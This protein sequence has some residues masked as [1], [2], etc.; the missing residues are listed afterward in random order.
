MSDPAPAAGDDD[1]APGAVSRATAGG[2]LRAARQAQGLHIAA[3]AASI[4]VPQ[5]K[6]E[7]LEADR[8]D[9]L[10]DLT[11]ARALA[12]TVCRSLKIDAAPVMALLPQ[13]GERSLDK[14][15]QGLNTAFRE[16]PGRLVPTDLS[17]LARPALWLPLLLVLAAAGVYLMPQS[18]IADLRL[19]GSA[20]SAV[21]P[22]SAPAS[23][24]TR[25][26]ASASDATTTAVFPAEAASAPAAPVADLTGTLQVIVS[27]ESW[28]EVL[29][30]GGAALLR[31]K[32]DPGE[33]VGLDG[34]PPFKLTIGNAAATQLI[35]RGEP[36][37]LAPA[38]RDN[39]ARLELN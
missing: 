25:A 26:E 37:D 10:P 3:L 4:K 17:V 30:A 20:A 28:V 5:R 35:L 33:A 16:R 18:W 39:V 22:P 6:L 11:F 24:Q 31:R 2:L 9:E 19:P 8:Y 14:V 34:T 21:S 7:A 1:V 23:A 12:Q 36:I 32:L 27:G 13:P 38:T 29:D 15:N